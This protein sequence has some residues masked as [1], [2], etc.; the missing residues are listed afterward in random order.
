[1][2]SMDSVGRLPPGGDATLGGAGD[3]ALANHI[4]RA[5]ASLPPNLRVVATLALV[6][7]VPQAEIA[8]ALDLRG[9]EPVRDRALRRTARPRHRVPDGRG[10]EP[11]G[12]YG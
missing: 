6:E 3:P 1:M 7:E 5:F 9:D 10:A 11:S 4:R 12:A 8:D 2:E